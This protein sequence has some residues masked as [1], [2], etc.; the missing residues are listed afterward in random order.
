MKLHLLT[1]ADTHDSL[2]GSGCGVDA[3]GVQAMMEEA[4]HLLDVPLESRMIRGDLFQYEIV[5]DAVKAIDPG[6]DDAVVFYYS[7]HGFRTP[8]KPEWWP[9]MAFSASEYDDPKGLGADE[10]FRLLKDRGPRLLMVITDCCNSVMDIEVT[11]R[12]QTRSPAG[13]SAEDNYRRLFAESRGTIIATSSEPGEVALGTDRGGLYTIELLN[14]IRNAVWSSHNAQWETVLQESAVRHVVDRNASGYQTPIYELDFGRPIRSW[15]GTQRRRQATRNVNARSALR[16]VTPKRRSIAARWLGVSALA[17]VAIVAGF[18]TDHLALGVDVAA[19]LLVAF[20]A[21]RGYEVGFLEELG[22]AASWVIPLGGALFA[23][24]PLDTLLRDNQVNLPFQRQGLYVL[25]FL[26]ILALGRFLLKRVADGHHAS[27]LD[28]V[29]GLVAG[30]VMG[31]LWV[32][33]GLHVALLAVSGAA[34]AEPLAQSHAVS[35]VQG[36][37]FFEDEKFERAKT[38]VEDKLVSPSFGPE[39]ARLYP[40]DARQ[41]IESASVLESWGLTYKDAESKGRL[42]G[43]R[44]TGK[45]AT[46][47][48]EALHTLRRLLTDAAL[49]ELKSI[50]KARFRPRHAFVFRSGEQELVLLVDIKRGKLGWATGEDKGVQDL[51]IKSAA[52]VRLFSVVEASFGGSPL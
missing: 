17:L 13:V 19:G 46:L 11:E 27:V 2:I 50:V 43:Y 5:A 39:V 41:I 45:V 33:I 3:E 36:Y 6:S 48:V 30:G 24:E 21:W 31:G 49:Y 38:M 52:A 15:T 4:A 34:W 1:V 8:N 7:G 9:Y 40:D 51:K 28:G 44:T 23:V 26:L 29:L 12:L 20:T 14:A 47:S 42:A 35:L 32:Y 37:N 16:A 25:L 18:F 22:W 10:V